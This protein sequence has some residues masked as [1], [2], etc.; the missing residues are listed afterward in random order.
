MD[1]GTILDQL[2]N[3]QDDHCIFA[4]RPWT[5]A[6][7]AIAMPLGVDFQTPKEVSDQELDYFL[8]VH[9]AKEALEVFG[10]HA[11]TRAERHRLL[12]FYAESDAYPDW[13]FDR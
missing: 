7:R 11:P 9:V 5:S 3:L 13:V 2:S 6:S 4:A 12:I 8:E 10:D 1:L